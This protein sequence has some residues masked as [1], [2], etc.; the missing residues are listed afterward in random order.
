MH[1]LK[2]NSR[3]GVR[4]NAAFKHAGWHSEQAGAVVNGADGGQESAIL[5][6]NFIHIVKHIT[7]Q[8][9]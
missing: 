4:R 9:W 7:Q 3:Q 5:L 1:A 2:T 8:V 6:S